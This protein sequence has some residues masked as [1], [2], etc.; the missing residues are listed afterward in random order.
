M[1]SV[2]SLSAAAPAASV[3]SSTA[4]SVAVTCAARPPLCA[5][6]V[7]SHVSARRGRP[8]EDQRRPPGQPPVPASATARQKQA[9]GANAYFRVSR[10]RSSAVFPL[11][12]PAFRDVL[13]DPVRNQVPDRLA[14][15]D[16]LP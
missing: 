9:S 3:T 2:A 5:L 16:A 11:V 10:P 6:Q 7:P 4:L 14:R 13:H 1:I 12:E 8:A 15:P